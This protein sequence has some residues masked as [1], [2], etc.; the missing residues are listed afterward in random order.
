MEETQVAVLNLK[1]Y[2]C[3]I[4]TRQVHTIIRYANVS[5]HK[6]M[7]DYA[8][9]IV[10]WKDNDIPVVNL[11]SR[12]GLGKSEV[13][14]KTKIIIVNIEERLTGFAVDD[15]K[16]VFRYSKNEIEPAPPVFSHYNGTCLSAVGKS[17][18]GLVPVLDFTRVLTDEELEQS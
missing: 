8:E 13:T 5:K 17:K 1:D 6:G 3:G 16:E 14:K 18:N 10:R 11:N 2:I 4:D 12:L 15:V 9:G 7:P